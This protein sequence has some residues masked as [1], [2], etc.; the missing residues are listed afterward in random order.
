MIDPESA[1]IMEFRRLLREVDDIMASAYDLNPKQW[2]YV[3][4]RLS[5]PFDVLEP[6]WPWKAVK[7]RDIQAYE[8]ARFA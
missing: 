6:R 4:V 7:M 5:S 2:A 1:E 8:A 3:E